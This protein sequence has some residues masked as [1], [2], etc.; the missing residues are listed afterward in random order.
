MGRTAGP[1][2]S[3]PE[4]PVFARYWI[5]VYLRIICRWGTRLDSERVQPRQEI[6]VA[7]PA[8]RLG[9]SG[10]HLFQRLTL[11]LQIGLGVMAFRGPMG[12]VRD[13]PDH[14]GIAP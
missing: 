4:K 13:G 6:L 2:A 8:R 7:L 5:R 14:R 12:G 11:R 3:N 9:R 10:G 1:R